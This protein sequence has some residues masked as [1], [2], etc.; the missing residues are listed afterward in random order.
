FEPPRKLLDLAK[1]RTSHR[2]L[3]DQERGGDDRDAARDRLPPAMPRD[4][5]HRERAAEARLGRPIDEAVLA[6]RAHALLDDRVADLDALASVDL[7]KPLFELPL[8]ILGAE[9]A[10]DQELAMAQRVDDV[11]RE[12]DFVER[13]SGL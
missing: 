12:H 3:E 5:Q 11:H 8:A 13:C 9:L 7:A 10:L 4:I 1:R 2:E 6:E